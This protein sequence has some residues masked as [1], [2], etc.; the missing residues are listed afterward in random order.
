[1]NKNNFL[2]P[3]LPYTLNLGLFPDDLSHFQGLKKVECENLQVISIFFISFLIINTVDAPYND[4]PDNTNS[5]YI[6]LKSV[7]LGLINP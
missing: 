2:G 6:E 3:R 1:M 4:T 7:S 5:R